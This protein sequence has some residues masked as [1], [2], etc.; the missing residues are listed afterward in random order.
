VIV[1]HQVKGSCLVC[2]S[3][4]LNFMLLLKMFLASVMG[5]FKYVLEISSE[6]NV[7]LGCRGI[8]F[9]SCIS[10]VEFFILKVCVSGVSWLPL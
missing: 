5:I 9:K 6:V 7:W 1:S 10:C 3:S 2:E 8:S 4:K